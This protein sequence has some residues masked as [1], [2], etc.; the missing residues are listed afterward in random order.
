MTIERL[1]FNPPLAVSMKNLAANTRAFDQLVTDRSQWKEIPPGYAVDITPPQSQG[2]IVL[3]TRMVTISG[4]EDTIGNVMGISPLQ[5]IVKEI[6]ADHPLFI[7]ATP[8]RGAGEVALHE[9][10]VYRHASGS[11]KQDSADTEVSLPTDID[12]LVRQLFANVGEPVERK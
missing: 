6:N 2:S 10:I 8:D 9:F 5:R 7:L 1:H 3:H 12:M 11:P 4:E